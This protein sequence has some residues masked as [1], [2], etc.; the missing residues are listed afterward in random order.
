MFGAAIGEILGLHCQAKLN[1]AVPPCWLE[2]ERWGFEPLDHH[3]EPTLGKAIVTRAQDLIQL[4]PTSTQG[5]LESSQPSASNPR[6]TPQTDATQWA[7]ALLPNLLC[8]YDSPEKLIIQTQ[9]EFI[10]QALPQALPLPQTSVSTDILRILATTISLILS[11]KPI[12]ETLIS[13]QILA[14]ASLQNVTVPSHLT[15]QLTWVD[16]AIA[17][18]WGLEAVRQF[19]KGQPL[20]YQTSSIQT[21]ALEPISVALYGFLSTPEDFRLSLLRVAQLGYAPQT[22]CTLTGILSG[23]Y[24]GMAGI[25]LSW[26]QSIQTRQGQPNS[27]LQVWGLD[28]TA[29]VHLADQLLQIW[30]GVYT[31][32]RSSF[33]YPVILPPKIR[34]P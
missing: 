33:S 23:A 21:A 31:P 1:E 25:P 20:P 8:Q 7:I 14:T 28:G 34:Y 13:D 4:C 5:L 3:L 26:L 17:Q 30:G 12:S 32:A 9:T 6:I 10:S 18:H 15:A 16:T 19:G 22:T 29:L 24:T 2:V 11:G 27:L